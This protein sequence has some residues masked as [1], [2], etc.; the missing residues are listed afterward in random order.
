M[1]R[2]HIHVAVG[3]LEQSIRFYSILFDSAP[4]VLKPDYAKWMLEDPRVNFAISER[5]GRVGVDHLGLQAESEAE[6][7]ELTDRLK[8]AE[9]ALFAEG[10][11]SCCYARSD[12]AW[13][14]DP[15]GIAWESFYTFGDATTYGVGRAAAEAEPGLCGDTA[16]C[17]APK[18]TTRDE[19][20]K[21]ATCC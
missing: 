9:L 4:T 15:Q 13:V 16:G 5:G 21:A 14:G 12:K 6:L 7:H 20:V 17:C 3:E 8:S 1:K 18:S 19:S 10:K 11:T 2:M